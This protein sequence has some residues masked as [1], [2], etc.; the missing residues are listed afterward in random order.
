MMEIMDSLFKIAISFQSPFAQ[1]TAST[2]QARDSKPSVMLN[3]EGFLAHGRLRT[4]TPSCGPQDT[5]QGDHDSHSP[6]FGIL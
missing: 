3:K 6:G 5:L 4:C 2:L 1:G